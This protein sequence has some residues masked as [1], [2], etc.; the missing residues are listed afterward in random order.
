MI[1][2]NEKRE[3]FL[4]DNPLYRKKA[5]ERGLPFFRHYS[6]LKLSYISP[7]DMGNL[8]IVDHI[9][10]TGDSLMKLS[11]KYYGDVRMWWVLAAFNKKPIDNLIN[12]G[13]II[14]IPVPLEE[15]VYLLNRDE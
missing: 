3:I 10:K 9:Y 13:D 15:A 2:R 7:E 14:H 12:I 1:D 5:K 8:T 6:K 11:F 4:N